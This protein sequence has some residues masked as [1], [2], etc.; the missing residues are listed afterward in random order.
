VQQVA[1]RLEFTRRSFSLGDWTVRPNLNRLE[2]PQGTVQLE[3]KHMDV[4]V[5]LAENAGRIV[6]KDDIFAAVWPQQYL[7]E[8][9]LTRAVAEIRRA[10]GDDARNPRYIETIT[11]RGYRLIADM[12]SA[13][14]PSGNRLPRTWPWLVTVAVVLL[15]VLILW[16][17]RPE[18]A[19]ASAP[20]AA[21]SP[22][23]RL[24][25]VTTSP[26]FDLFP[27]LSPDG[28]S[29]VYSSD[30]SG[31]FELY[32]RPLTPGGRELPLTEDGQDNIQP[33]WSPDGRFIVYHSIGRG[34]IWSIP[35]LGGPPRQLVDFGSN[36]VWSPDS[37]T[38]AFESLGPWLLDPGAVA[39]PI[40]GV[41]WTVRPDGSSLRQVTWEN[42]PPRGHTSP[43]FSPDGQLLYFTNKHDLW[44]VNLDDG[45]LR[46]YQQPRSVVDPVVSPVGDL[47]YLLSWFENTVW[48]CRMRL[49]V[50]A[51]NLE[52]EPLINL[53]ARHLA[54]SADGRR[55]V[56][57]I[58]DSTSNL[59]SIRLD[60][61]NGEPLTESAPL[62]S[63]TNLRNSFPAWSP[64]GSTIV[65]NRLSTGQKGS[66]WAIEP[67][68]TGQRE[69]LSDPDVSYRFPQWS[70]DGKSLYVL[71][72]GDALVRFDP[73]TRRIEEHARPDRKWLRWSL[74]PSGD[75]FAFARQQD[76]AENIWVTHL[77]A[78][79]ATQIT[80]DPE[81]AS[82]PRWSPDGEWIAFEQAREGH[83]YLAIVPSAGG[84]AKQLTFEP[85]HSWP[86]GWSPDG[87]KVAFAGSRDGVWNI[88]WVSIDDGSIRQL[89][90]HQGNRGSFVRYPAWSPSGDQIVYELSD[91][92]ADVWSVDLVR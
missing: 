6:S 41:I 46:Q 27:N 68:G 54:L 89:T 1:D 59:W 51:E 17:Q 64:D 66:I 48:L 24:S 12:E 72:D 49:D 16:R 32:V 55:L 85:E 40:P 26:A 53:E 21:S 58:F 71:R 73:E 62:T 23:Y 35:A 50:E 19:P 39:V 11:K 83:T 87:S 7:A 80:F 2:G 20:A 38:I 78:R 67:D 47:V 36:P 65:F 9:A 57:N 61:E 81:Y 77:D 43:S 31:S 70:L 15:G 13:T 74:A 8:S 90:D 45:D 52:L 10:L 60:P 34:G 5:F 42:R 44:S 75:R 88:Y 30:R 3:P 33:A 29:L 14:K 63:E 91:T 86:F 4:L 76:D 82:F 25:Q 56:L 18:S 28:E 84:E 37:S 92:T 22:P 79:Q 69:L